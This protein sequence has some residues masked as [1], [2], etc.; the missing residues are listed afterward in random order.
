MCNG[1]SRTKKQLQQLHTCY[2][3]NTLI[4]KNIIN[5]PAA[6]SCKPTVCLL[7]TF[8]ILFFAIFFRQR[9]NIY[10]KHKILVFRSS[11]QSPYTH[12]GL[13]NMLQNISQKNVRIKRV[14]NFEISQTRKSHH[15]KYNNS[16]VKKQT[17]REWSCDDHTSACDCAYLIS[18][19]FINNY[20]S[21]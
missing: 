2:C 17:S 13:L 16:E 19:D 11:L 6:I 9:L 3:T 20:Y 1:R 4:D 5:L 10:L 12:F 21:P 14:F 8:R 7:F 15:G 18:S